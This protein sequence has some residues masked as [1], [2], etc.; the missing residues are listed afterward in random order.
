METGVDPPL[1]TKALVTKECNQGRSCSLT[2]SDLLL[3][4]RFLTLIGKKI[5]TL[6]D[7]L[8]FRSIL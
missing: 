7:K 8:P 1:S 2:Q 5:E 3:S 6:Q 4:K